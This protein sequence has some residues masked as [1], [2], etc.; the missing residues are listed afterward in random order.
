MPHVAVVMLRFDRVARLLERNW[1]DLGIV[2]A[3][4]NDDNIPFC[5]GK[6]F[7]LR[8]LPVRAIAFVQHR[9]TAGAFKHWHE[10]G[11]MFARFCLQ[12]RH[13]FSFRYSHTRSQAAHPDWLQSMCH[14]VGSEA[15][16]GKCGCRLSTNKSTAYSMCTSVL[17][18]CCGPRL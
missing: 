3:K 10:H 9:R 17:N 7:V 1:A 14:Q 11:V 16:R 6:R 12:I 13:I 15:V 2:R 18:L 4:H 5:S 8:P